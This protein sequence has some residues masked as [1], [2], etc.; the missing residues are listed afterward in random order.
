MDGHCILKLTTQV[1]RREEA[2][3]EATTPNILMILVFSNQVVPA[4]CHCP[5]NILTQK[6]PLIHGC[7][8]TS[9]KVRPR[10]RC[11]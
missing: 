8:S 1:C 4:T 5:G 2:I 9:S 3:R 7:M 6:A 11:R 10:R